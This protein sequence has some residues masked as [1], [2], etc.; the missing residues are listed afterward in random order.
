[1]GVEEALEAAVLLARG[2]GVVELDS[3]V[4][5]VVLEQGGAGG[6]KGVEFEGELGGTVLEEHEVLEAALDGVD[7]RE[8]AAAGAGGWG[9]E[10]DVVD[11]LV[12]LRLGLADEV[13]DAGKDSARVVTEGLELEFE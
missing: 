7:R 2:R 1:M 4:V 11:S 3:E 12:R 9:E 13:G 10:E 8:G 6:E 5:V